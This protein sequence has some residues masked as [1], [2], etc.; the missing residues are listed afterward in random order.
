MGKSKSYRGA[1]GWEG[2]NTN[3]G[4]ESKYSS[5]PAAKFEGTV[6]SGDGDFT[7]ARSGTKAGADKSSTRRAPVSKGFGQY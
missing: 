7:K 4:K 3:T 2:Q 5:A 1:P 6:M